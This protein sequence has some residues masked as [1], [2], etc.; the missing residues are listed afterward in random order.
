MATVNELEVLSKSVYGGSNVSIPSGWTQLDIDAYGLYYIDSTGFKA[1][2]YRNASTNEIVISICGTND[3]LDIANDI[4]ILHGQIFNQKA[5][6]L[7][8][9]TDIIEGYVLKAYPTATIS[10]TG[11]S[12]GGALADYLGAKT[13]LATTTFNAPGVNYLLSGESGYTTS[14][15][16]NYV[17][18]NDIVGTLNYDQH[19]GDVKLLYPCAMTS[20]S[21]LTFNSWVYSHVYIPFYND[22]SVT[23]LVMDSSGWSYEKLLAS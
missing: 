18:A 7:N 13:E 17:M 23:S 3:L 4:A 1:A 12:L 8:F 6:V 16:T 19:I 9:Y 2:I 15:I 10:I 20:G 11:H 22:L 21:P 5:S 14:N